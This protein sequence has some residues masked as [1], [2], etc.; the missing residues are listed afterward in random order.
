M[1]KVKRKSNI[2]VPQSYE[3]ATSFIKN[4]GHAQNELKRIS[5]DYDD[6]MLAIKESFQAQIK[7]QKTCIDDLI[8]GIQIYCE[9]NRGELTK[10]N[11]V[12][13]HNF[14]TGLVTWRN[15]SSVRVTRRLQDELIDSLKTLKLKR[16]IRVKEE[17]NKDAVLEHPELVEG[18]DGIA[19]ITSE[20]FAVEPSIED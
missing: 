19:V 11:K 8:D 3:E 17:I 2:N 12:K 20:S 6:A 5:A 16:F 1:A 9:A 4:V 10:N 14:K 18:I 15:S 7:E 13:S